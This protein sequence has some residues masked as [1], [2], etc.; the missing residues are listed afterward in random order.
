M[1]FRLG[2]WLRSSLHPQF[3][4]GPGPGRVDDADPPFPWTFRHHKLEVAVVRHPVIR[5]DEAQTLAAVVRHPDWEIFGDIWRALEGQWCGP[6]VVP[7]AA[8]GAVLARTEGLQKIARRFKIF[9]YRPRPKLLFLL[10]GYACYG[11]MIK[12]CVKHRCPPLK[13]E[14]HGWWSRLAP[15]M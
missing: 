4:P 6:V 3:H 15:P 1:H 8:A 13:I 10:S 14:L 9:V 5:D 2:P 7:G 12:G 11:G